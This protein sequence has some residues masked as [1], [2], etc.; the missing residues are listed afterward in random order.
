MRN[1]SNPVN[2]RKSLNILVA[3]SGG[4]DSTLAAAFLKG[5]GHRIHGLHFALPSPDDITRQRISRIREI[6]EYLKIPLEIL[7]LRATFEK[8]LIAPFV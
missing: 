2:K 6:T 3:M 8:E 5:S 7:D 1:P 4:V